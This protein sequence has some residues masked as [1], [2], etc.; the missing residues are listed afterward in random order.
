MTLPTGANLYSV[1]FGSRPENV[2]IPIVSTVNPPT[3]TTNFRLFVI[4]KRWVNTSSNTTWTLTSASGS[5]GILNLTWTVEGGGSSAL[6][7]LTGD[8]GTATPSGGS[9]KIAGDAVNISTA[10][11][12]STITVTQ[13]LAGTF[14][15]LV[16][17]AA[18]TN[19]TEWANLTTGTLA[20]GGTAQTGTITLGNSSGTQEVDIAVGA[21]A[22]TVKIAPAVSSGATVEIGKGGLGTTTVNIAT[23]ATPNLVTIGS[24]NG[25]A[26]TTLQAG[27]GNLNLNTINTI[28]AVSSAGVTLTNQLTNSD[29]TSGT[30]NASYQ[31]AVG[32]ASSGDPYIDFLVSGAG[33]YALGIDNSVSDNFVLAASGT[34]GTSNIA[35]WTSA[36]ALTNAAGITATTGNITSS[37]GNLVTVAAASGL[38]LVPTIGSGAAGGTVN[39]NG[40]VGSV[41]FTGP[42][43]AAGA[44]QSL[45]VGNTSVT[46]S[47]TVILYS[48]RGATTGAAICIQNVTNAA[49]QSTIVVENGTGATTQTG[50]LTFDFI[51]LN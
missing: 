46:G 5:N 16:A 4:G 27:S 13:N 31:V 33:H 51:V 25:V 48:M 2:E 29:N 14:S 34:L 12:G 3:T 9:I 47:G 8:T 10:G 22:A 32:G 24:T 39:C 37:A 50:D 19:V 36:G 26:A 1:A 38:V 35:S 28:Q 11:S 44:T 43:I 40:R 6:S 45:V 30:S 21:G 15:S 20:I 18:A 23:G 42:S 41:T 17:N 7:Q 49:N